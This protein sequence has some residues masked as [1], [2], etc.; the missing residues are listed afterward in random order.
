MPQ[1]TVTVEKISPNTIKV[2]ILDQTTNGGPEPICPLK[3]VDG[4]GKPYDLTKGMK[5]YPGPYFPSK[6]IVVTEIH[7]TIVYDYGTLRELATWGG[8]FDPNDQVM[9]PGW[10]FNIAVKADAYPM[11]NVPIQQLEFYV[12]RTHSLAAG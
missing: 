1:S 12:T 5:T 10:W 6:N 11:L 2:R 3:G 7:H 4:A 9:H 8:F